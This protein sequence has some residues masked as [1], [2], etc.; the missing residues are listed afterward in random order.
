M[1]FV[2]DKN[3]RLVE[4][5]LVTQDTATQDVMELSIAVLEIL[6]SLQKYV[7]LMKM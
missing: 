4:D 5:Q 2:V 7:Q 1:M 6:E 3:V